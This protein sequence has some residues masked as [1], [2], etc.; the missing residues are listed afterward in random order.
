[1][2]GDKPTQ[3]SISWGEVSERESDHPGSAVIEATARWAVSPPPKPLSG[4]TS[5]EYPHPREPYR[6]HLGPVV[7]GRHA[8]L[9]QRYED[10]LASSDGQ[11]VKKAITDAALRLVAR[12]FRHYGIAPLF[13]AA[14]YT[15]SLDVGPD[16]EG[17]KLNNSWRS[18]L[19][20][21]LMEEV[22]ALKD[23]FETRQLRA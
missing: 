9:Q 23:F 16:A 1:M 11:R 10:W 4:G 14:R 8:T 6:P 5:R 2:A 12:G 17:W 22:P 20:R 15:H 19:S 13:E 18:R 7:L 3:V 21:D